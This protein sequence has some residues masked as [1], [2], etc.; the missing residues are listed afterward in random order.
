[1]YILLSFQRNLTEGQKD[2][3]VKDF[4]ALNLTKYV[5]E[6]VS[7]WKSVKCTGKVMVFNATFSV[8]CKSGL[9]CCG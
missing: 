7:I 9:Y 5:G 1:M 2:S 4:E 6:V 8:K 3:L